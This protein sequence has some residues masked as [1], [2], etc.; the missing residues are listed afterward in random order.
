MERTYRKL[1]AAAGFLQLSLG[2]RSGVLGPWEGARPPL[3]EQTDQQ[4]FLRFGDLWKCLREPQEPLGL[5]EMETRLGLSEAE[6]FLL[7]LSALPFVDASFGPF[8]P[9]KGI[10]LADALALWKSL[11]RAEEADLSRLSRLVFPGAYEKGRLSLDAVMAA[12][13][14]PDGEAP[15]WWRRA[16]S[17]YEGR[18]GAEPEPGELSVRLASYFD[19]GQGASVL[20]LSGAPGSGRRYALRGMAD[21]SGRRLVF[22]E[23]SE[24]LFS[25]PGI[26]EILHRET[27]L[28][29]GIPVLDLSG[30]RLHGSYLS[31]IEEFLF[32]M[33]EEALPVI[34]LTDG[35]EGETLEPLHPALSVSVKPPEARER[36]ALWAALGKEFLLTE[37]AREEISTGE[38]ADRY[39]LV[40]GQMKRILSR[41]HERASFEGRTAIGKKELLSGCHEE[42][43]SG[44]RGRAL[45][46]PVSFSWE[47]LILD[48]KQKEKLF[49]A[50]RQIRYRR[51]VF[52][53]WGMKEKMPYGNGISMVFSGPPGT[54]KTMAAQVMA[55]R[56]GLELY[57]VELATV[58]SKF[59]GE[60]EK[61]LNEIFKEAEASQVV[62]FFDEADV[63]FGKRTEVKDSNDKYSN[64]EA[65]FLLQ[66]MESY[67]GVT[68]LAT[69]FLKNM[70]EAFKRRIR[71]L[72]E[73]PFP[74]REWRLK[75][76]ERAFPKNLPLSGDLDLEFLSRAFELTGAGI[77]NAV[78]QAAFLAVSED[79]AVGMSQLVRA[80][81]QEMEKNGKTIS[82]GELG[83]YGAV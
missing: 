10:S 59:I 43:R 60:T 75:I 63:L 5:F 81:R 11:G 83:P 80:A 53:D 52:E 65:A 77:R 27:V 31:K 23:A 45:A 55:G 42:L 41:A 61:N 30:Q 38:L 34:L 82:D 62:L 35:A 15:F 70:D 29:G 16:V 20:S 44:L 8:F 37:E 40:P 74:D 49:M 14:L 50:E 3:K 71:F 22:V 64:M 56:M 19:H 57:K 36:K 79:S 48:G 72:V 76:W 33:K 58:V 17:F 46:V 18:R 54:G 68:I 67:S 13:F 4:I 26:L 73:F 1:L 69:N 2:I 12:H 7:F 6:T 78:M 21:W 47:E 25:R 28:F 39:V 32:R 66:K 9:G 51:L 24:E